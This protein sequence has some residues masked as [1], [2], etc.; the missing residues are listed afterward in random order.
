MNIIYLWKSYLKR[1]VQIILRYV[2]LNKR[3][4]SRCRSTDRNHPRLTM[5]W[6]NE[7]LCNQVSVFDSLRFAA[8]LIESRFLAVTHESRFVIV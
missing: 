5:S 1:S 4:N 2:V 3:D 7:S 8:S 6:F